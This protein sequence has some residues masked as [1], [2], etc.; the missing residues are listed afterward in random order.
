MVFAAR[1]LQEKSLEQHQE[2]Y[3]T[4]VDLTKVFDSVSREGLWKIMI[5]FGCQVKFVKIVKQF[6]NGM[7][8]RGLDD[9][10][11]SD[12]FQVTNGV[13]LGC[14]LAPT[15]LSLMFSAKL[16]MPSGSLT[17]AFPSNTGAV[18]SCSSLIRDLLFADDCTLN[19]NKD[20]EMQLDM[21]RFSSACD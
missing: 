21:N 14:V 13:K 18:A 17:P 20:K 12:P 2:L 9:G 6:Y 4:F 11:S 10:N 7:M 3:M 5:K 1:Q 8:A 15:L 19:A 16:M